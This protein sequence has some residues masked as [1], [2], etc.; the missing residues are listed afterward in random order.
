MIVSSVF[1]IILDRSLRKIEVLNWHAI[2]KRSAN[3]IWMLSKLVLRSFAST[4]FWL[5][6]LFITI[7]FFGENLGLGINYNSLPK[8]IYFVFYFAVITLL[9]LM[10]LRILE[11]IYD[12]VI[13]KI[14]NRQ[15]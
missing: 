10:V 14:Y 4:I 2:I 6:V 13:K 9:V 8:A 7:Y 1:S 11:I 5:I 12:W 15:V 3:E